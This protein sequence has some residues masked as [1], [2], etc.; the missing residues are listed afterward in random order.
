MCFVDPRPPII[1]DVKFFLFKIVI[2]VLSNEQADFIDFQSDFT[3]FI[4]L[5]T[6]HFLF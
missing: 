1:T 3:D 4:H 5:I 2:E 6:I